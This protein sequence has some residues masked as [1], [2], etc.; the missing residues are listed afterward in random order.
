[1][2]TMLDIYQKLQNANPDTSFLYNEYYKQIEFQHNEYLVCALEQ[3]SKAV[4]NIKNNGKE[5]IY[6]IKSFDNTFNFL[7]WLSLGKINIEKVSNIDINV[8]HW[9]KQKEENRN[10]RMSAPK[11]F[12]GTVL[13]I[14]IALFF[15]FGIVVWST[16][17]DENSDGF[18][19]AVF[20]FLGTAVFYGI[21]LIKHVNSKNPISMAKS[22]AYFFGVFWTIFSTV[23]SV[24]FILLWHKDYEVEYAV[25]F[26]IFLCLFAI[27]LCIVRLSLKK[28]EPEDYPFYITRK[29]NLPP[30]E[31]L[32]ELIEI[33][34]LKTETEI[35]KINFDTNRMPTIYDSKIG[36]LPYCDMS[37]SYPKAEEDL[38]ML[39]QINFSQ[40]PENDVF[41]KQGILQLFIA[42]NGSFGDDYTDINGINHIGHKLVYYKDIDY[43][44]S[45]GKI[46][47][48]GIK[49]TLDEEFY[50][51]D[52]FP[53]CG[54]FAI[55][56][57][58]Q[59]QSIPDCDCNATKI[60]YET[61]AELG[62]ELE[63]DI[64]YYEICE[65]FVVDYDED[66]DR[67]QMSGY[68]YFIESDPRE[69][70]SS[71]DKEKY[72]TLLLKIASFYNSS[73]DDRSYIS[74]G[75]GGN[76]T[77]YIN[78]EKLAEGDFSD[79]YYSFECY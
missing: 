6:E 48:L 27:S 2:N 35:I 56:F 17:I 65:Q 66:V 70:L 61:A 51:N 3:D 31:Q 10:K 45:T 9:Y 50:N 32:E 77:L 21:N 37:I 39:C 7:N 25:L 72:D 60:M 73:G 68:A 54:E 20:V 55:D 46:S 53:V 78:K 5:Y 13:G 63:D 74:F 28:T 22:I 43:P 52:S 42:N 14:L 49:T 26:V 67:S 33:I 11:R 16:F 29:L 44:V 12:I 40:L 47:E 71:D 41:P 75:D 38:V 24:A 4:I 19:Y 18:D 57:E 15:L 36:G 34:K 8:A 64:N 1:M 59:I 62:I 76:C 79:V 69:H 30:K 58:K 23:M